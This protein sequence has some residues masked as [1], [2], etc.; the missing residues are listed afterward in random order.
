M[1]CCASTG[2]CPPRR[3][4]WRSTIAL[5][6]DLDPQ[7]RGLCSSWQA[8]RTHSAVFSADAAAQTLGAHG[9]AVAAVRS[10]TCTR[11][12]GTSGLGF[13]H[14]LFLL[15]LLL[16]AVLVRRDGATLAAGD[17]LPRRVLRRRQG[18]DRVHARA[19]DHAVAGRAGRRL[20]AVAAG[21]VGDR[22]LRASGGAQQPLPGGRRGRWIVAFAFGLIHGFGFASVL[23]DLGLPRVAAARAGRLQPRR[24]AGSARDRR[25]LPAAVRL[26]GTDAYRRSCRGRVARDH[27][28]RR[29]VV[30]RARLQRRD[31]AG[32]RLTFRTGRVRAA[33]RA[34][35]AESAWHNLSLPRAGESAFR[36]SC[37]AI[38]RSPPLAETKHRSPANDSCPNARARSRTSTGTDMRSPGPSSPVRQSSMSPAAKAMARRCSPQSPSMFTVSTSTMTPFAGR[39]ASTPPAPTSASFNCMALPF[40]YRLFDVIVSFETIEHIDG[41]CQVRMLEEFDRL[42]KPDGIL[43]LSSPNKAEYSDARKARNEFHVRELY[44]DELARLLA[45]HFE[46][47]RWFSQ[48]IQCWS[49]IW[50]DNPHSHPSRRYRSMIN[51]YPS[52]VRPRRCTTLWLRLDPRRPLQRRYPAARFLPI[53]RSRWPGVTKPRSDNSFT[54]Q[55]RRRVPP[56][57]VIDM[58][59]M[60]CISSNSFSNASAA[61]NARGF[62]PASWRPPS[63]NNAPHSKPRVNKRILSPEIERLQKA[64]VEH[65]KTI[66]MLQEHVQRLSDA[67]R[68]MYSWRWWLRYPVRRA[69]GEPP[70]Q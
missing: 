69:S 43:I 27:R 66:G 17:E 65:E 16:P 34:V 53:A 57:P 47:T 36:S 42:L 61:S 9:R 30:R 35:H 8:G 19:F 21:R 4:R 46:A 54:L 20:A 28:R 1:P 55:P 13:D 44:R 31:P 3:R 40:P 52:T 70:P 26:R 59:S 15:S 6:F 14:I 45:R 63:Q 5:L 32:A 33:L 29:G 22:A 50:S 24:R 62:A 48:R 49:G 18:R 68:L 38:R 10:P 12:S 7:H 25:F 2:D 51:R 60:C 39:H 67:V 41:E 11:V 23:A 56:R 37:P 58:P 64:A